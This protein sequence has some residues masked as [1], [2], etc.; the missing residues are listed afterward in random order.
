VMARLMPAHRDVAR[1]IFVGTADACRDVMAGSAFES[2]GE[3]RSAGF[4]DVGHPVAAGALGHVAEFPT[5]LHTTAADTVVVC[6][7]VGEDAFRTLVDVTLAAGCR[8]LI[9]S[10][11][12]EATGAD[13]TVVRQRGQP[14]L[15]V[16]TPALKGRQLFV[17]R[18]VDLVG[19]LAGLVIASP[20]MLLLAA[21]IKLDSRGPVVFSQERLGTG[22]K[23]FRVFKFRTMRHGASDA[24]HRE[25]IR[26]LHADPSPASSEAAAPVYKLVDD[27]RVTRVGRW[28]RQTSLDELPQLLNVVRGDMSL[29]GPRPPLPY[30]LEQYAHWQFDRLQVKPGLTGLWQV[31]GRSRMGYREMCELDLEY[32]R[33]WSLW[34]DLKIMVRTIPVVLFNS[35]RA[36]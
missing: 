23:R 8:L 5:L 17:K 14:F 22:G 19:G 33:R 12:V 26:R 10:P 27:E 7:S 13:L 29:V 9:V 4:V 1:T 11:T 36:A 34:L 24:A 32:V 30:E 2:D 31:S 18:A 20:V 35:G 6:G 21:A 15:E 3:F 16:T 25:L 28:L